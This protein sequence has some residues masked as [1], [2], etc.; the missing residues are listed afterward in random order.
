M[1]YA[2]LN[3]A[4]QDFHKR[5]L[6]KSGLNKFAGYQYFELADFIVPALEIFNAHGLCGVVSFGADT[7]TLTVEDSSHI[8]ITSPMSTAALKGCHEVQNLGAVQTYLRRYLWVAALEIVEHDA[9]DS[10]DTSK[11][12][13]RAA[14]IEIANQLDASQMAAVKAIAKRAN[15]LFATG[16]VERAVQAV[17]SVTDTEE[18]I[19]L[20]TMISKDLQKAVRALPKERQELVERVHSAICDHFNNDDVIGAYEEYIG[21][22]DSKE[23]TALWTKLSKSQ[24][25]AL[26][27]HKRSLENG[28]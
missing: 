4:R 9:V 12:T 11:N 25:E 19:A 27:N 2:K 3:A 16:D 22:T 6:S 7:A 17:K 14:M 13:A 28:N 8:V 24:K 20:W 26:S 18:G 21:I 23:K 5:Q 15:D 10:T 1:I